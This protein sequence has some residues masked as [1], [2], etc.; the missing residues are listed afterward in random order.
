M[1]EPSTSDCSPFVADSHGQHVLA[2]ASDM[3]GE[4]VGKC[5]VPVGVIAQ[6]RA[7]E[8]DVAVHVDA[9]EDDLHLA[10]RRHGGGRE[11]LAIPT[12]AAH[13]PAGIPAA[14]ARLGVERTDPDGGDG[15]SPHGPFPVRVGGA[16]RQVFDA[17]VMWQVERAPRRVIEAG[18]FGAGGVASQESPP[19]V[20]RRSRVPAATTAPVTPVDVC[21]A[22]LAC[23]A[24][25]VATNI[26]IAFSR[27]SARPSRLVAAFVCRHCLLPLQMEG[28]ENGRR[29]PVTGVPGYLAEQTYELRL[30]PV[31]S[32][33]RV[34][35][36]G[37]HRQAAV[38]D[39]TVTAL[40]GA[41]PFSTQS[42]IRPM[43][44]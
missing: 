36:V 43:R 13:E 14:L 21:S 4:V 28:L 20:E 3:A 35:R 9:I 16:G 15:R 6:Q 11:A 42:V 24:S 18:Q 17:E 34:L 2:G 22:L 5:G 41:M 23:A 33:I 7:V 10:P 25:G 30:R 31:R 40:P 32:H 39:V 44:S 12:R 38:P 29:P 19:V 1:P 26:A 8:P 27:F 37:T